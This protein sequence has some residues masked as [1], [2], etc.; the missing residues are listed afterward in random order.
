MR[1]ADLCD[2]TSVQDDDGVVVQDA[3]QAVSHGDDGL[4]AEVLPDDLLHDLIGVLVDGAGRFVQDQDLAGIE[5]RARQAEELLLALREV[6]LGDVVGQA[7]GAFLF[8]K[9]EEL[10]DFE[11]V[12]DGVDVVDVARVDVVADAAL[13]EDT[14]LG[15][16]VD[17]GA[18]VVAWQLGDVEAVDEDLAGAEVEHAEEGHGQGG[19]ATGRMLVMRSNDI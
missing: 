15:D 11:G 8:D 19:F 1:V 9:L 5:Q 3:L 18:D 2:L 6:E 7:V 13:D 10:D 16:G 4:A 12:A 17:A 14:V